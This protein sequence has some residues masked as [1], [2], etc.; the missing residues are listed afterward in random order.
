[1][2]GFGEGDG[3]GLGVGGRDVGA[4]VLILQDNELPLPELVYPLLQVQVLA[5]LLL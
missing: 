2:E 1:M 3:V 5:P 4:G